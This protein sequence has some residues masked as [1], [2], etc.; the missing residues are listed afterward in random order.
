[1]N[2]VIAERVGILKLKTLHM[3]STKKSALDLSFTVDLTA[4]RMH[5][6][7]VFRRQASSDKHQASKEQASS[8]K[9]FKAQAPSFDK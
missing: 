4:L 1:M 5:P 9:P 2:V 6:E 7:P 8:N 3:A